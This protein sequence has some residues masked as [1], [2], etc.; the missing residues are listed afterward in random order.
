M[1]KSSLADGIHS[2]ISALLDHLEQKH[3]SSTV[4]RAV[5]YLTLTRTGLTEAELADLL[6][7]DDEV[8][9]EYVQQDDSPSSNARVPQIDV[10]RFLLDL[11]SFLIRRIVAG[12]S[13]MFW[14]S[15]HFKLVLAKRYLGTHEVRMEIHSVMADYFTGRWACASA[16]PQVLELPYHLQLSGR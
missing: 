4:A 3:S 15:R 6:S 14:V 9:A 2:S 10:E 1:T 5:S 12:S 16:K 8:L 7:S 13:V 11:W